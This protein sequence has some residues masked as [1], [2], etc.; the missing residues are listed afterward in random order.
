MQLMRI[1]TRVW[2]YRCI[3]DLV[4]RRPDRVVMVLVSAVAVSMSVAVS[5]TVAMAVVDA[6][7]WLCVLKRLVLNRSRCA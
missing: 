5:L 7:V 1:I 3:Y 2:P 4:T 6:V